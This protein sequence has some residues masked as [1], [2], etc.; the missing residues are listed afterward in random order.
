MADAALTPDQISRLDQLRTE[1]KVCYGQREEFERE[2]Q[3]LDTRITELR[4][5]LSRATLDGV[6]APVDQITDDQILRTLD[7]CG[8]NR[9][10][11]AEKLGIPRR[12]VQRC[13]ERRK[14]E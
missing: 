1:L 10:Q 2:K 12:R 14:T 11:A 3:S 8:G 13:P 9:T 6:T 4:E 7:E 5:Q